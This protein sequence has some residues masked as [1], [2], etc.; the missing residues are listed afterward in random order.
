[1]LVNKLILKNK[2]IIFEHKNKYLQ[3]RI[4]KFFFSS[5]FMSGS[6]FPGNVKGAFLGK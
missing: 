2:K 5:T 6:A 4:T 1:M 3:D